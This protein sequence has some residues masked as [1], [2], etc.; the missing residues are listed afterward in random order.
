VLEKLS[1]DPEWDKVEQA[2]ARAGRNSLKK[3]PPPDFD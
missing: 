2:F 3:L 1:H